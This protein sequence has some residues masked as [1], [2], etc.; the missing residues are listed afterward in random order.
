MHIVGLRVPGHDKAVEAS[1]PEEIV[2]DF[3]E[4]GVSPVRDRSCQQG[5]TQLG[6]LG[7]YNPT[8]IYFARPSQFAQKLG[9]QSQPETQSQSAGTSSLLRLD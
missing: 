3:V 8:S 7:G 5:V 9:L 2:I 4:E 6:I 1:R